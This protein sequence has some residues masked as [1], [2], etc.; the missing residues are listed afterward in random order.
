[1]KKFIFFAVIALILGLTACT[2]EKSPQS[3]SEL[4]G[5]VRTSSKEVIKSYTLTELE[6]SKEDI[7]QKVLESMKDK[8]KDYPVGVENVQISFK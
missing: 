6:D 8:L 1:M 2:K 4:E 3:M 5:S 7:E